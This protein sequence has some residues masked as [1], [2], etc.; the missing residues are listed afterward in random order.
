[1]HSARNQIQKVKSWVLLDRSHVSW[2]SV[3]AKAGVVEKMPPPT[4]MKRN[5]LQWNRQI[6]APFPTLFGT[7]YGNDQML[8]TP[9]SA[10][11]LWCW[12]TASMENGKAATHNR[13]NVVLLWPTATVGGGMRQQP[14]WNWCSAIA[15]RTT[16]GLPEQCGKVSS[17]ILD[18]TARSCVRH[19]EAYWLYF[20]QGNYCAQWPK[21]INSHL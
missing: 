11:D 9:R 14:G 6:R 4:D 15:K 3:N 13:A 19:G 16:I 20:W 5:T 18:K 17:T 1:M 12:T 21:I 10:V 7:S 8:G 2:T